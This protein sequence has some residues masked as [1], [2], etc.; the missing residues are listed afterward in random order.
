MTLLCEPAHPPSGLLQWLARIVVDELTPNRPTER[1]PTAANHQPPQ[2]TRP[3]PPAAA[4][5]LDTLV[6]LAR[7]RVCLRRQDGPAAL[8]SYALALQHLAAAAVDVSGGAVLA[9]GLCRLLAAVATALPLQAQPALWRCLPPR[10]M[11]GLREALE[12]LPAT[13]GGGGGGGSSVAGA[14]TEWLQVGILQQTQC[15][16]RMMLP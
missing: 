7:R 15:F 3:L 5:A 9:A 6:D 13:A 4:A 8:L 11:V 2:P 12:P 14:A 10:L 16:A 1:L